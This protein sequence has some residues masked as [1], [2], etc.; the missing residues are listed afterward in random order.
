M[1]SIAVLCFFGAVLLFWVFLTTCFVLFFHDFGEWWLGLAEALDPRSRYL[2]DW[3]FWWCLILLPVLGSV[4]GVGFANVGRW[5]IALL[6]IPVVAAIV[7]VGSVAI[8][9]IDRRLI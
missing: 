5:Q 7:I 2:T 4:V 1:R 9:F 3:W 8:Y 6:V